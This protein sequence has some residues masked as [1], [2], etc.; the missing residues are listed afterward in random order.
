VRQGE[1]DQL[2]PRGAQRGGLRDEDVA[3]TDLAGVERPVELAELARPFGSSPKRSKRSTPT[4]CWQ[5]VPSKST[6]MAPISGIEAG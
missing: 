3:E 2:V 5:T 4:S 1:R 6:T